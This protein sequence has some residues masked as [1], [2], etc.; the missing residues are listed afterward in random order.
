MKRTLRKIRIRQ[1]EIRM[2][3][4]ALRGAFAL[5]TFVTI[6]LA[7]VLASSSFE[8]SKFV[9]GKTL[10]GQGGFV[11][12]QAPQAMLVSNQ[13]AAHGHNCVQ[14]RGG[15]LIH[16]IGSSLVQSIG[17]KPLFY[18]PVANGTPIVRLIANV[19]LDG[20]NTGLGSDKVSAELNTAVGGYGFLLSLNANGNVY[21]GWSGNAFQFSTPF[22]MGKYVALEM[23]FDFDAWT[24]TF[25]VNGNSIGSAP[26]PPLAGTEMVALAMS[27]TAVQG[28][29][30][31]DQYTAYFDDCVAWVGTE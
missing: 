21:G 9:A 11:V 25:L 1:L 29:Q 18:D 13:N 12:I 8:G 30:D 3:S 6:A 23:R 15:E 2:K 27:M 14:I 16:S 4:F 17:G 5:T 10:D 28:F 26:L 20:D 22:E 19:R 7:D 24:V 31:R